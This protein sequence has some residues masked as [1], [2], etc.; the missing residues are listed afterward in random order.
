MDD[1]HP[2]R[3]HLRLATIGSGLLAASAPTFWQG[4]WLVAVMGVTVSLEVGLQTR[5]LPAQNP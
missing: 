1:P 4:V 2:E 3:E 5:V